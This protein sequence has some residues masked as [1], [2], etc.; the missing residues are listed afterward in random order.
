MVLINKGPTTAVVQCVLVE[1]GGEALSFLGFKYRGE[2]SAEELFVAAEL[3]EEGVFR[4]RLTDL[5]LST[6]S[7]VRAYA[8]NAVGEVYTGE[9]KFITD[10][11]IYISEPGTLSEVIGERLKYELTEI[12]ISGKLNG[13]DFRLLRDMLGRGV[14]GEETA[15][16]LNRLYLTD[17]QVV[18]GE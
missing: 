18:E 14:D 10:N 1:D 15:G 7:A 11:A 13:S 17:V 4:A 6:S 3:E 2:R 5:N 12:S 16:K 8:A 9:V